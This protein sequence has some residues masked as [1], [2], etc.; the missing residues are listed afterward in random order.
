MSNFNQEQNVLLIGGA[1]RS[2]TTVIHRVLCSAENTNPYISESWFLSDIMRM[3]RWNL[4]RYDVRHADQFGSVRN[5]RDLIW[6]N[7]R[8]Y[9]S[10]VSAKYNDPEILVL[11]HPELT[12]YFHELSQRFHNFR[13]V[14]IVRDPRDVI[15]SVMEVA[16]RHHNNRIASPQT[17]LTDMKQHCD[18]Y[19]GYYTDVLHHIDDFGGRLL[20][21][22]YEDFMAQPE[23]S[24]QRISQFAGPRY[25]V[26]R[27]ID[28]LPEHASAPNFN[29]NE[30]EKDPFSG[31]FWSDAYT[32]P[33]NTSRIGRYKEVMNAQ[34]IE[35]VERR[36]DLFGNRF[37]YWLTS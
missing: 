3:Y 32:Q 35:E 34:Q 31:A 12:Y 36:L 10:M 2:G 16:Q 6:M 14:V 25:D 4:T 8:H 37:G 7:V 23:Q 18:N 11:K 1:M 26:S 33:I 13:F 24:L 9:L 30:R 22:K 29:K 27:A 5:F 15:A 20:F 28:F 19:L 21:V 17:E